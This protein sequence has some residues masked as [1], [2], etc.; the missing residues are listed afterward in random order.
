MRL[1]LAV[2][3]ALACLPA[4]A[5]SQFRVRLVPN[6]AVPTGKAQCDIRLQVDE[7]VEI[8]L[9]RDT[10]FLHTLSGGE[11]RDDGS[12]CTQPLP[13]RELTGFAFSVQDKRNRVRL[14]EH[15]GPANNFAIVVRIRDT[16]AGYGRYH[17]HLSWNADSSPAA[18]GAHVLDGRTPEDRG[19]ASGLVWNNVTHYSG[20]GSGSAVYN[21]EDPLILSTVSLDIDPGNHAML[22]FPTGRNRALVILGTVTARDPGHLKIDATADDG[23]LHGPLSISLDERALTVHSLDLEATDGQDRVRLHWE[24]R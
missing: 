21:A 8:T 9:R 7:E 4:S 2:L 23:R 11:A 13:A 19:S 5:D 12:E 20:R 24:R 3:A 6:G 16:E 18:P 17:F 14:V 22:L 10:V 1:T 15:P